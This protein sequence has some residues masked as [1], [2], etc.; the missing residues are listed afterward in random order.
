MPMAEMRVDSPPSSGARVPRRTAVFIERMIFDGFE[1]ICALR[2]RFRAKGPNDDQ[3]SVR[4]QSSTFRL[5]CGRVHG[6]S[7]FH[8]SSPGVKSHST[9]KAD[10]R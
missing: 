5:E 10:S 1:V 9:R 4:F 7:T 3:D 2:G 6:M 8:G